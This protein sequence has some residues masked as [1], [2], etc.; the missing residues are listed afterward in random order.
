MKHRVFNCWI[1]W[2]TVNYRK[3]IEIQHQWKKKR[4][5]LNNSSN[6]LMFPEKSTMIKIQQKGWVQSRTHR[7]KGSKRNRNSMLQILKTRYPT[8]TKHR[9]DLNHQ[10]L[11]IH[12]QITSIIAILTM[13]RDNSKKLWSVVCWIFMRRIKKAWVLRKKKRINSRHS[14]KVWFKV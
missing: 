11:L 3:P 9:K 13:N 1:K 12:N 4:S 2:V 14:E 5:K 8:K 7:L 6:L 10:N